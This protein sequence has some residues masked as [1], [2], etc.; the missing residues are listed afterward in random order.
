M[1]LVTEAIVFK[2]DVDGTHG[3]GDLMSVRIMI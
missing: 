2:Q 3:N 1:T